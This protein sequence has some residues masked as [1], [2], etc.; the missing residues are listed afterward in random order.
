MAIGGYLATG[1]LW[2]KSAEH[3]WLSPARA[4]FLPGRTSRGHHQIEMSCESCH[5]KPFGG[6]QALQKSCVRCHGAELKAANDTHPLS[7]FTD[8][9]NADLLGK[10]DATLCVTCHLEHRPAIT[11][12][13]GVTL[14][15]DFCFHCHAGIAKDRPS[16]AGLAFNTCNSAGCHKFHD[17]RALY[18]D[19][20]AKH[21]NEPAIA[22]DPRLP[23]RAPLEALVQTPDYP[24]DRYPPRN[25]AAA[26]IDGPATAVADAAIV[27]DW[28]ETAHAKAGVNCS[29]CHQSGGQSVA[30]IDR[31]GREA[32]KT[33]HAVEEKGF[34]AGKHGMRAAEGLA[35]MT[36]AR[37]RQP[38]RADAHDKTLGCTSCHRAHRFDTRMAAVEACL[39]CHRDGHSLA[40]RE[41]PHYTLWK[42]ELAGE[43]PAGGGVS[44]A[45][46]H[47]P[48]VEYRNEDIGLKRTLVQHNQNDTLQPNEKMIRPVCM[49]CH[50]LGYSI[51]ALADVNLVG[52]NF[53]GK[54]RA[55][56]DSLE[57]VVT[58]LRFVKEKRARAAKDR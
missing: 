16:H 37:A 2:K 8:P 11:L 57:M 15:G 26:A 22:A 10:L 5:A 13:M 58:R 12:N 9:R 42:K 48:R 50:G 54:P 14:A 30:W 31:P 47:L 32:C 52:T 55:H 21:L 38:M 3:T 44:C 27:R 35:P 17:N 1:L 19:F 20:L 43:L 36:A 4:A 23:G 6:K 51:D 45:S 24:A 7:K 49:T 39:G 29:A 34:L 25:L 53:T 28:L 18:E 40:Y 46:C 41:S 56:V 33:C